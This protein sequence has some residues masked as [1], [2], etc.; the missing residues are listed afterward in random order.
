[1][2]LV[3]RRPDSLVARHHGKR[4]YLMSSWFISMTSHVRA[5]APPVRREGLHGAK[6][7]PIADGHH[8]VKLVTANKQL[9]NTSTHKGH[10]RMPLSLPGM[11]A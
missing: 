6:G 3:A 8:P 5:D 1:L 7:H 10:L 4:T 9:V 2:L 11:K